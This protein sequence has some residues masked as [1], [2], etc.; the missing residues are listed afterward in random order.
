MVN[1]CVKFYLKSFVIDISYH[2]HNLI[3]RL[4]TSKNKDQTLISLPGCL[5][6]LLLISIATPLALP[7]T[8]LIVR[9]AQKPCYFLFSCCMDYVPCSLSHK[10]VG[11]YSGYSLSSLNDLE[12]FLL[13][14]LDWWYPLPYCLCAR[15]KF[16]GI[17]LY[18]VLTDPV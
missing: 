16:K 9:P 15:Y 3:S 1:G 8:S 10:Y 6:S 11:G 14:Y 5:K 18:K 7:L 4:M 17:F 13:Y 12:N 2:F